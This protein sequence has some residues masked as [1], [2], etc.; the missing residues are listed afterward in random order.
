[1]KRLITFTACLL[2]LVLLAPP[3]PAQASS[4]FDGSNADLWLVDPV[5]G[6]VSGY[7]LNQWLD[8]FVVNSTAIFPLTGSQ[9][10][11]INNL[12]NS[13]TPM[14]PNQPVISIAGIGTGLDG[15]NPNGHPRLL[16]EPASGSYGTTIAVEMRVDTKLMALD[17]PTLRWALDGVQQIRL[18]SKDLLN[19]P[20]AP[21]SGGYYIVS[22][23]IAR[24]GVHALDVTLTEPNAVP[25]PP[26]TIA[27]ESRSYTL[28]SVDVDG[29][30]RDTDGDGIP[31]VIEAEIGLDPLTDDWLLDADGDGWSEFDAWLR[32]PCLDPLTRLVVAA[33]DCLD[34]DGKPIDT[35]ADGWSD[36]D[37][38]LRGTNHQD[39]EPTLPGND[40]AARLR[41]KDF[42]AAR[43]LYEVEKIVSGDFAPPAVE[44]LPAQA[45]EAVTIFGQ[46]TFSTR[47]LLTADDLD[48]AGLTAGE[49]AE[50]LQASV[51]TLAMSSSQ[52]PVMRLPVSAANVLLVEHRATT[53]PADYSRY[54]KLWVASQPDV[55]PRGFFEQPG[56]PVYGSAA[57]W[58]DAFVAY[59]ASQLAV[60]IIAAQINIDSTR[61]ATLVEGALSEESRQSGGQKTQLFANSGGAINADFVDATVTALRRFAPV[62]TA[63][64]LATQVDA[65]AQPGQPLAPLADW[66]DAQFL[67]NAPGTRSDAFIAAQLQQSYDSSCYIDSSVVAELQ[68]DPAAWA[69][70]LARCPEYVTE[71]ELPA[72][73]LADQ[74]RRYQLRAASLPGAMA[75]LP[76][77]ASLLDPGSDSDADNRLNAV[78]VNRPMP[79]VT[80]PWN[81]DT[82]GDLI[83]DGDDDC[84][85]DPYNACSINPIL[86]GLTIGADIIVYEPAGQS[87]IVIITVILERASDGPV[88]VDYRAFVG[89]TDTAED[90]TDFRI[91]SGSVTIAAGD[92]VAIITVPILADGIDEGPETF[93]V[94]I[95]GI[96]GAVVSDDGLVVVT[97]NDT[98][99]GGAPIVVLANDNIVANERATVGMS[100]AGSSDPA[101]GALSFVWRQVDNGQPSVVLS[102]GN[103]AQ[104]TFTAP[105]TLVPV[106]LI[107]EVTATNAALLSSTGQVT[108]TVNP[109][110]D[111]PFL[112]G[113]PFVQVIS[114]NSYE[115]ADETL[116]AYVSDPENDPLSIGAISQQPSIGSV[117]DEGGSFTYRSGG[118]GDL[119]LSDSQID[120]WV[121]LGTET[122]VVLNETGPAADF[123]GTQRVVAV[124]LSTGART[125]LLEGQFGELLRA[126]PGSSSIY[127][128]AAG[129]LYRYDPTAAQPLLSAPVPDPFP[130]AFVMQESAV[131]PFSGD[132]HYCAR[133]QATNNRNWYRIDSDDLSQ[134]I[135]TNSC[136]SGSINTDG[137]KVGNRFCVLY[138]FRDVFC[139]APVGNDFVLSHGFQY[140]QA[141]P[142]A[143]YRVIGVRQ[144][145]NAA[146]VFTYELGQFNT[147]LGLQVW[148]LH[149]DYVALV[150]DPPFGDYEII[151]PRLLL[152][153][154]LQLSD[155]TVPEVE[156][157]PDGSA[158]MVFA[159]PGNAIEMWN[160]SGDPTDATLSQMAIG[161]IPSIASL[162]PHVGKMKYTGGKLYWHVQDATSGT[163]RL[164]YEVDSTPGAPT[165][166]TLF[167]SIPGVFTDLRPDWRTGTT[168]YDILVDASGGLATL[169]S[170]VANGVCDLVDLPAGTVA[171]SWVG[172]QRHATVTGKGPL[173]MLDEATD[174]D[175][176]PNN[177]Y[178]LDGAAGATGATSF[179]VEVTDGEFVID[180]PVNIEVLPP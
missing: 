56:Q 132:L 151:E 63:D 105:I 61:V 57:E 168:D 67:A 158:V 137:F 119:K 98:A 136:S 161:S 13:S 116:L 156:T 118:G 91:V 60:E 88:T 90:G 7:N 20:G 15:N 134:S 66:V 8:Q 126:A 110:N 176:E 9:Q 144:A 146:I 37:E 12:Q 74:A 107:F 21:V 147:N 52:T 22:A 36:F 64:A 76:A 100:A 152:D 109:V 159:E 24:N 113:T 166:L 75:A 174:G 95:T 5:D 87:G 83:P 84:N 50:R 102:G 179:S 139:T 96:S 99:A 59:L 162:Y 81:P 112:T 142:G 153:S 46:P 29:E 35:D 135:G 175:V 42:P 164:I 41:Y 51:A 79:S 28:T 26:R 62:F 30:G 53:A 58:R 25:G 78:E 138:N 93:S 54:Y 106:V 101:G 121:M 77:D 122:H 169:T 154:P 2:L 171:R 103:T 44:P 130:G 4:I 86:P 39:P 170:T 155:F 69:A 108:V 92:R 82:D 123:P 173:L 97:L 131:D 140:S 43:R 104:A 19:E 65:L 48:A 125:L 49:V 127:F 3:L 31:D 72:I 124:D 163:E 141:N 178:L 71:L 68:A 89:A 11:L 160:W 47:D 143:E 73:L 80:L 117:V 148:A 85:V 180:L 128:R 23:Y 167:A 149:E 111:P 1:M 16:V 38:I 133:D 34:T 94:E 10:A 129:T 70:F 172:C 45:I 17:R 145:G 40:D 177:L 157:L 33:S 120:E 32:S 114:G 150:S 6:R 27:S 115:W 55:S 14:S 165:P 18:L